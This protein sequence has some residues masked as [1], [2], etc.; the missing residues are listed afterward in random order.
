MPYPASL[1]GCCKVLCIYIYNIVSDY[2]YC[3]MKLK[4]D[5][6]VTK[7]HRLTP[8]FRQNAKLNFLECDQQISEI[9]P[10]TN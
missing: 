2:Q 5:A 8:W 6:A 3:N 4:P 1:F 7:I 9:K 10:Q